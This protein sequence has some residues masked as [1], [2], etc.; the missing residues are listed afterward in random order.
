MDAP[1]LAIRDQPHGSQ[2][3]FCCSLILAGRPDPLRPAIDSLLSYFLWLRFESDHAHYLTH[4]PLRICSDGGAAADPAQA[5]GATGS[6]RDT[7]KHRVDS[8]SITLA[9]SQELFFTNSMNLTTV[10]AQ[11]PRAKLNVYDRYLMWNLTGIFCRTDTCASTRQVLPPQISKRSMTESLL[12]MTVW[13]LLELFTAI[14]PSSVEQGQLLVQQISPEV[15][16]R[17]LRN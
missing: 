17:R 7:V 6:S 3:R 9:C 10:P 2:S 5:S 1:S 16:P 8:D 4:L 14:D 13:R 12:R 11:W 15:S